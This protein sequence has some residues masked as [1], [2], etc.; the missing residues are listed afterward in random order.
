V[1]PSMDG[2]DGQRRGRS[3]LRFPDLGATV[4]PFPEKAGLADELPGLYGSLFSTTDWFLTHDDLVATGACVLDAPRHVLLFRTDGDTVNVL[5]GAF[6]IEPADARRACTALFRAMPKARRIHLEVMFPHRDLSLPHRELFWTDHMVVQLPTTVDEYVASLGAST[7]RNLRTYQNRLSRDFP[8]LSTTVTYAGE[9]SRDL[10]GRFLAWQSTRF[11]SL[12]RRTYF[13][14]DQ[15]RRERFMELLQRR[16]QAHV[17]SVHGEPVA[18]VFTF[19][20]GVEAFEYAY[21]FNP[22]YEYYHL[23][24]MAQFWAVCHAIEDAKERFNLGWGSIVD[25]KLRLG[26]RPVRATRLSVFRS[27]IARAYSPREAADVAWRRV[28]HHEHHYFQARR[29]VASH[30]RALVGRPRRSE[31]P[32]GDQRDARPSAEP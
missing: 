5:N 21:A 32:R 20:V 22:T 12:G 13:D 18:I 6:R 14:I 10:F 26:A 27:Q 11:R 23:G 24:L 8:D 30:V 4:S 3:S 16:G 31:A 7:R 19:P 28:R 2:P 9:H 1:I 17:T 15:D 25:Y 29:A